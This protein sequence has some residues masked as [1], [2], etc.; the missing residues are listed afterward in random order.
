MLLFKLNAV[1]FSMRFS[2]SAARYVHSDYVMNVVTMHPDVL[3]LLSGRFQA[4]IRNGS[5]FA[6]I[7][8]LYIHAVDIMRGG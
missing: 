2:F 6:H 1:R 8:L 4:I 5:V 7:L 3:N